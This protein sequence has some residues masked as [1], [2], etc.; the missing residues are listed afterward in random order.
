MYLGAAEPPPV[1][2]VVCL[3]QPD[4]VL[5]D[6]GQDGEVGAQG[7][8]PDLIRDLVVEDGLSTRLKA[9]HVHTAYSQQ[10]EIRVNQNQRVNRNQ[11]QRLRQN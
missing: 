4:L 1:S 10:G 9:P 7:Q 2:A 6:G 5:A 3:V 11:N 8:G